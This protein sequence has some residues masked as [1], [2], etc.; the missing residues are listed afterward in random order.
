MASGTHIGKI[1][2]S[3]PADGSIAAVAPPPPQPLVR[4]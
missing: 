4:A 1:V 3:V 2:I